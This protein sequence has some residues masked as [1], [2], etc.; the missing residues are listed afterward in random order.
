MHQIPFARI[1]CFSLILLSISSPARADCTA[2]GSTVTCTGTDDDGFEDNSNSL[3]VNAAGGAE[4]NGMTLGGSSST[5]TVGPGADFHATT[6]G[7]AGLE[8]G[9]TNIVQPGANNGSGQQFRSD[10]GSAL[11]MAETNDVTLGA[12]VSLT[13][14]LDGIVASDRNRIVTYDNLGTLSAGGVGLRLGDGNTFMGGFTGLFKAG[15]L[16]E[17]ADSN[18]L[19]ITLTGGTKAEIGAGITAGDNNDITLTNAGSDAVAIGEGPLVDAG[20]QTTVT[21]HGSFL[22]ENGDGIVAGDESTVTNHGA[23]VSANGYGVR[24]GDGDDKVVNPWPD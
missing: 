14:G 15:T 17:I 8:L 24:L 10:S 12:G 7:R 11:V 23:L 1:L 16:A 18:T 2:E 9:D 5:L 6:P 4:I 22:V 13:G 19:S 20:S 21:L 3:T